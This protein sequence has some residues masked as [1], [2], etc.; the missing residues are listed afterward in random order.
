MSIS[1]EPDELET[2]IYEKDYFRQLLTTHTASL[3]F[4][5]RSDALKSLLNSLIPE[6]HSVRSASEIR[7]VARL[8]AKSAT[9]THTH[10]HTHTN[11]NGTTAQAPQPQPQPHTH[12]HS[13][14]HS[15]THSMHPKFSMIVAEVDH[16]IIKF[17]EVIHK[18]YESEKKKSSRIPL[19]LLLPPRV[20]EDLKV[21]VSECVS[22]D[23][24]YVMSDPFTA[25]D[26]FENVVVM[27]HRHRV[28]I[29]LFDKLTAAHAKHNTES[30]DI[31]QESCVSVCVSNG[32][33]LIQEV[34]SSIAEEIDEEDL[35][36]DELHS[37]APLTLSQYIESSKLLL[38]RDACKIREYYIKEVTKNNVAETLDNYRIDS[39]ER[40]RIDEVILTNLHKGIAFS[41]LRSVEKYQT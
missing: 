33:A 16:N 22:E 18:Y 36:Q 11:T 8:L 6:L 27:L 5:R 30:K 34:S 31:Q 37:N 7:Q 38:P 40:A 24:Y 20:E 23:V 25:K 2:F 13:H 14:T 29:D 41:A 39:Q 17:M 3:L 4:Y 12:N 21:Y 35:I 26:V 32:S 28:A 15:H 9:H 19:L 10:T 1:T